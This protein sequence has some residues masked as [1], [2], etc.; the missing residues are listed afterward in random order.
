ML[1]AA[2]SQAENE[3]TKVTLWRKREN[4]A[5]S[6]I[7][8]LTS[9]TRGVTPPRCAERA[10]S[11]LEKATPQNRVRKGMGRLPS[12]SIVTTG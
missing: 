3:S 8:S 7:G 2:R 11:Q 10:G 4:I 9:A 12:K 5:A 6:A 1:R